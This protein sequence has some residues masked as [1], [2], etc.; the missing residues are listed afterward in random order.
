MTISVR[1]GVLLAL[2]AGA[3]LSGL[4]LGISMGVGA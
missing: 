1:V 4:V 3:F 2:L